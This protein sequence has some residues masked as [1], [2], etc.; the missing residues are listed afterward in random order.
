[1]IL[2]THRFMAK[3]IQFFN[4][5][6]ERQFSVKN[7]IIDVCRSQTIIWNRNFFTVYRI[8]DNPVN[9]DIDESRIR[10]NYSTGFYI[11]IKPL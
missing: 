7:H 8:F 10:V 4:S 3:L 6:D 11:L 9:Y 2:H 1:M 5:K